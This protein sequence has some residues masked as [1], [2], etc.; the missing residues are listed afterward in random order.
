MEL[1][2]VLFFC[3]GEDVTWA[4]SKVEGNDEPQGG[5]HVRRPINLVRRYEV[6]R[7]PPDPW[8]QW[9]PGSDVFDQG[10]QG[11]GLWTGTVKMTEGGRESEDL[12]CYFSTSQEITDVRFFR[13]KQDEYKERFPRKIEVEAWQ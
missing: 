5:A 4:V 2:A 13:N 7:D 8:G 1:L 6:V 3:N 11:Q 9:G 10:P 12:V